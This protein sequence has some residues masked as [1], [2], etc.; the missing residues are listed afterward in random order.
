[1]NK[2]SKIIVPFLMYSKPFVN[3]DYVGVDYSGFPVEF[4]Y[5]LKT[6]I[7]GGR[8][9]VP[10]GTMIKTSNGSKKSLEVSV[11][12]NRVKYGFDK[13]NDSTYVENLSL[14][15]ETFIYK[16]RDDSWVLVDYV[17]K[18]NNRDYKNDLIGHSFSGNTLADLT[19]EQ[20]NSVGDT[21]D[22]FLFGESYF[23]VRSSLDAMEIKGIKVQDVDEGIFSDVINLN[24][25]EGSLYPD[26]EVGFDVRRRGPL[27]GSYKIRGFFNK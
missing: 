24:Q 22:F 14:P 18:G 6:G 3:H 21:I 5:D 8:I 11:L 9:N 10:T 16:K 17:A 19:V 12:F 1:M 26:F 23:F 7:F 27:N 4:S 20:L 2:F 25:S 15:D 13:P